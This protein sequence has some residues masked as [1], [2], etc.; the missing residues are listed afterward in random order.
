[1]HKLKHRLKL[2][3]DDPKTGYCRSETAFADPK[4]RFCPS[5]KRFVTIPKP[6]FTILKPVFTSLNTFLSIPKRVLRSQNRFSEDASSYIPLYG[7]VAL[8]TLSQG[9]C[10]SRPMHTWVGWGNMPSEKKNWEQVIIDKSAN[11][12]LSCQQWGYIWKYFW[13]LWKYLACNP[14][15][16]K[17]SLEDISARILTTFKCIASENIFTP[18]LWVQCLNTLP[19]PLTIRISSNLLWRTEPC[20]DFTWNMICI[21]YQ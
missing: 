12:S 6:S 21:F 16:A 15:E 1:M 3:Y 11:H 2:D 5:Q 13:L 14:Q 20:F 17:S 10:F 19:P 9:I 18:S 4:T 8:S 7:Y